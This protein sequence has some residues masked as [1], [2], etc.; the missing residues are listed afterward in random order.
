ME[1]H[2]WF[3]DVDPPRKLSL[4][5]LVKSDPVVTC[6]EA[7]RGPGEGW[8]YQRVT[9]SHVKCSGT[10]DG[11][12]A[13]HVYHP[14]GMVMRNA[15]D[16]IPGRDMITHLDPKLSGVLCTL[17]RLSEKKEP[18]VV[19]LGCNL[20]D[21]R[22]L[23]P[24]QAILPY[25]IAPSVFLSTGWVRQSITDREL[26]RI[27]DIPSRVIEVL[28][29]DQMKQIVEDRQLIPAQVI[30]VLGDWIKESLVHPQL[31]MLSDKMAR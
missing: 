12:W 5:H 10:S 11:A 4:F 9:L 13:F 21:S 31:A 17:P 20:Y 3:S 28:T 14:P 23:Y 22:G 24:S 1:V 6:R 26:C 25:V 16:S 7:R 8:S 29:L 19:Q 15:P 27:K 18:K 30:S 2:A